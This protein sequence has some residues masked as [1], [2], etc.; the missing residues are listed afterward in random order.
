MHK[1]RHLA[2]RR[3]ISSGKCSQYA[4]PTC[5]GALLRKCGKRKCRRT[6]ETRDELPS[7]HAHPPESFLPE[8]LLI[9]A[10]RLTP[11]SCRLF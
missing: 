4:D 8:F 10:P 9:D 11:L 2:L 7:P 1:R 5:A 3:W 6:G